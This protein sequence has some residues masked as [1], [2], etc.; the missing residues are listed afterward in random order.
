MERS[1]WENQEFQEILSRLDCKID[2]DLF[3]TYGK[4]D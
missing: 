2:E 3:K 1:P 4:Q